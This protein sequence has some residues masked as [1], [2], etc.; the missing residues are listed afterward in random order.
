MRVKLHGEELS[1]VCMVWQQTGGIP[2]ES[3]ASLVAAI[4]EFCIFNRFIL[5]WKKGDD[6][7]TSFWHD[8]RIVDRVLK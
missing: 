2:Q 3:R 5:R 6:T 8:K 4:Q 1:K 7:R